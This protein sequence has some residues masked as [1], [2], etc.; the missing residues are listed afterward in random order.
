[1]ARIKAKLDEL[2]RVLLEGKEGRGRWLGVGLC[3]RYSV[4]CVGRVL[5]PIYIYVPLPSAW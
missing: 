1:M 5:G 4:V 2:D 3:V